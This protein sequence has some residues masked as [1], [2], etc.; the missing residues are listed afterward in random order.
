MFNKFL[1]WIRSVINKMFN[2]N[3]GNKF[4]VNIAISDKMV[5]AINLWEKMYKDEAPWLNQNVISTGLPAAISR[6][7]ATSTTVEFESEITGSK[8]ADY[9]NNKYKK[10][11]KKLRKNLEY[12]CSL[13]GL[14]FKPYVANGQLLVDIVKATNF[15]PV[16]YDSNEEC[17]AGIFV[18]RKIDGKYYY[19][20]LEYHDLD[21]STKKYIIHNKAYMSTTEEVLGQ[22][23]KL[24]A[25]EDWKN[26]QET[27]GIDNIDRP[28][29]GYFKIPFA[30]T[31][32]PDSPNGVSVYSRAVG[33]IEEAD[34]QFSRLL[35]EF[36]GS[37]LAIDADPTALQTSKIM[38][39][40]LELPRL[41][42]RLFRA[43]G[44][45]KDGKAFYEVFSPQIRETD[46]YKGFNDILKRIEFI[47][48]MA[49]G[50]I[51]DPELIEK[52]A[53]EIISAKQRS[54]ATIS[55]IQTALE[56]A[57]EDTIYAMDVLATLYHLAPL[58][59]YETSY[60]WDDSIIVDAKEE[61]SIMMQ[62]ANMGYI[63]KEIYLMKRYGV[64]EEQAKEMMPKQ[65]E[66]TTEDEE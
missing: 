41:K 12:G 61:Q 64:T 23:I 11:K 6:E 52:T 54:Y 47:C 45:N 17:T 8:R 39:D 42:D 34:K 36:E 19:T 30:N 4:N 33:L 25:V 66:E 22:E 1:G 60:E 27:V 57:L 59:K 13:G 44:T 5:K 40:K 63:K 18:S 28:L 43:T 29:F 46:L 49:Y 7:F 32:D 53:T 51:S 62:E 35:W 10:L 15:F 26:I 2:V 38:S 58:G 21:P 37:E 14:V 24:S 31:I 56:D 9:L 3:I 48:G 20:R 55:D 65:Q 50:T 16:S